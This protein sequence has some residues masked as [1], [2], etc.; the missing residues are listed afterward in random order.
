M[1][2]RDASVAVW[3]DHATLS[4]RHARI[5]LLEGKA[6]L[7]D[8]GSKNGTTLYG[9]AV[10][11]PTPLNSGDEF[12]CGQLQFRYLEAAAVPATQTQIHTPGSGSIPPRSR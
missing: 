10:V 11:G 6:V 9:V 5:T 2:G 3:V 12:T 4:R 1:I 8:L 7:E